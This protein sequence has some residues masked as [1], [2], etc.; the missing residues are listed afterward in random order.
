ML[1]TH[2]R[3][4]MP[5]SRVFGACRLCT[6]STPCHIAEPSNR[7]SCQSLNLGRHHSGHL[8]NPS[9]LLDS[10]GRFKISSGFIDCRCLYFSAHGL[11]STTRVVNVAAHNVCHMHQFIN[12]PYTTSI[13]YLITN[14]LDSLGQA[15]DSLSFS[16]L[17][18]H[19]FRSWQRP[20]V[21]IHG[22][23]AM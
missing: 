2:T 11:F 1:Q 9:F 12:I 8:V 4:R 5:G 19:A 22:D 7:R 23:V 14:M 17:R 20:N 3:C 16:L 15:G 13:H 10:H 18:S 6:S 21:P